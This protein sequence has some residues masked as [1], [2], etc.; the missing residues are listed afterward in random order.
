MMIDGM[1]VQDYV[2]MA[3]LYT[4]LCLDRTMLW[5]GS[6]GITFDEGVNAKPGGLLLPYK[7]YLDFE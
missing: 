7:A 6:Y 3:H 4:W 5:A 1:N 2:A